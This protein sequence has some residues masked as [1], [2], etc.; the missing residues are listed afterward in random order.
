VHRLGRRPRAIAVIGIAVASALV[1]AASAGAT[2]ALPRLALASQAASAPAARGGTTVPP[3]V[4]AAVANR[5]TDVIVAFDAS[6]GVQQIHSATARRTDAS[7]RAAGTQA[8]SNAYAQAKQEALQ[9]AGTGA[10]TQQ[11]YDHLPVQV[12]QVA[13]QAALDRLAADPH[14]VGLALPRLY[15]AV[16]ANLDMIDQPAAITH[17]HDGTGATVAILDTGLDLNP[18]DVGTTF[19]DCSGGPGTGTCK[20]RSYSQVEGSGD[21][22]PG[23][24]GTNVAG[25]VATVA[26]GSKIDDFGVFRNTSQGLT[27]SDTDIFNALNTVA[28]NVAGQNIRAVNMSLAA[29]D[30]YNTAA[31]TD[32]TVSGY[33]TAFQH[34]RAQGVVPVVASGNDAG[35]PTFHDGVS[36][37]ACVAAALSVGAVYTADDTRDLI[38]GGGCEDNMP[39]AKQI[40]CFSQTGPTLGVLAPGTFITAAG[41]QE[42][43]TSQAT[44]H[45]AGGIA[46]IA[47]ANPSATSDQLVK[48]ITTTGQLLTDNRVFPGR[49]THLLDIDAAATELTD[50]L[51][52]SGPATATAGTPFSVTVSARDGSLA[53]DPTF[54]KALSFSSSDSAAN[55]PSG[56]TLSGGTGTFS[57]TLHTVGSFTVTASTSS[58]SLVATTGSITVSAPTTTTTTTTTMPP[59]TTTAAPTPATV[60]R[61]AGSDRIGTSI[62][63]S[64]VSFPT[65]HS[66]GAAVLT[67]AQNFPDGL[68]GTPLAVALH[69]PLL[70]TDSSSVRTDLM[71]EIAR[72][73]PSGGNIYVLGGPAA[74]SDAVITTLTNAGFQVHR[75][76]GADRY[77]TATAIADVIGSPTVVLLAT[78][79]NFPDGLAAGV[80]AAHAHGVVLFTQG[81]TQ[82]AATQTW[83]SAH[84]SLP[85]VVVGGTAATVPGATALIG[86]DRYATSAKVA[87][88]FFN[89]P[90]V[91]GVASGTAFP[92]ALSGGAHIGELGGPML[93]TQPGSLPPDITS[94]FQAN[95]NNVTTVFLY[96][97]TSAVAD[98]VATQ[99][100]SATS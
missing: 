37:P 47:N 89:S 82:A 5:P 22:E 17:G 44:P 100:R 49:Q 39:K 72:A 3:D 90:T 43:G 27:A 80:A 88:H 38:W 8:A 94:W 24:H 62:E 56:A 52:A 96:G 71:T 76:A 35:T 25:I 91:A 77:A 16:A 45:V 93:L 30:N 33:I 57:V 85:V 86:A 12:V 20:I 64:Q 13:S 40:A 98:A 59:T 54:S 6:A 81:T 10:R 74:V 15:R 9:R 87:E 36:A 2:A 7:T 79:L 34:L 32:S 46:D 19:G 26:P 48:A 83:L 63:A 14:V 84:A 55:L 4:S 28:S 69:A 18:T 41:F 21:L 78:G 11:D 73:I 67:S 68:A 66:A 60:N 65:A 58:P 29:T 92:D 1:M 95:A 97:G 99:V 53:V 50:S 23:H 51:F 42:S 61:I 31:C 70:L 75:V